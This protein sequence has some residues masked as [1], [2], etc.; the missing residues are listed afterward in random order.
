M[1]PFNIEEYIRNP[2]QSVVTRDG[3]PVRI[4]CTDR[5]N[6]YPILALVDS[7]SREDIECYTIDGKCYRDAEDNL[8]LFFNTKTCEGWLN[9]YKNGNKVEI[10]TVFPIKSEEE[11]RKAS[12]DKDYITTCRIEW[13][14]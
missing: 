11:A 5:K 13:E 4:V 12:K 7:N 14:E 1:K 10:G 9:L 3:K 2:K 8:D 6:E